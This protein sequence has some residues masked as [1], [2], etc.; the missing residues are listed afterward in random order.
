M[1]HGFYLGIAGPITFK[2]ADDLRSLVYNLPIDRLLIETDC[3]LL[4]PI[5][6]RGRRNEPAYLVHVGEMLASVRGCAPEVVA[7]ATSANA[8]RVFRLGEEH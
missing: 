4:A 8:R 6:V 7:E 3:P 2:K 5:P 1:Q